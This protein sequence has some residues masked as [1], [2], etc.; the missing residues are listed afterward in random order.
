MCVKRPAPRKRL[1]LPGDENDKEDY[2]GAPLAATMD[3]K[4]MQS[5]ENKCNLNGQGS[6]QTEIKDRIL[7]ALA[8][9][10]LAQG[11]S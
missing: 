8:L 4:V 3:V 11:G 10:Q 6:E 7:G 1:L 9:V 5:K 2:P